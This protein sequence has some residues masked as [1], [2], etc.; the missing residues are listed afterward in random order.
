[1][2]AHVFTPRWNCKLRLYH[3]WQIKRS[4]DG[5]LYEEC[6]DCGKYRDRPAATQLG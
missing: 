6:R 1:M 2:A 5:G 4:D 3:R